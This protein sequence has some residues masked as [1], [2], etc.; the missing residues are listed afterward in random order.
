M[1]RVSEGMFCRRLGTAESGIDVDKSSYHHLSQ[2]ATL[3]SD[4]NHSLF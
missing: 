2:N 3:R 4:Q 1:S